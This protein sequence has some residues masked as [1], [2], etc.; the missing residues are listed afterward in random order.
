MVTMMMMTSE[1]SGVSAK[2]LHRSV[3][4]LTSATPHLAASPLN[5]YGGDD[6]AAL[7]R[8]CGIAEYGFAVWS[9]EATEHKVIPVPRFICFAPLNNNLSRDWNNVVI[10]GVI[11]L[12]SCSLIYCASAVWLRSSSSLVA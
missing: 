3:R 7:A 1:W 10:V 9:D 12:V 5:S 8:S 11:S 6:G 2:L 4:Q